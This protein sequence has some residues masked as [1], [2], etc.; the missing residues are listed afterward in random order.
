M[1]PMMRYDTM[2]LGPAARMALPEPRNSP[3]PI[4]PPMAMS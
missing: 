1:V 3:V 4:A 2:M